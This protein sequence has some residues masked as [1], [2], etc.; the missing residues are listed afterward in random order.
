MEDLSG[1]IDYIIDGGPCDVGVES[2]VVDGLSHPPAILRPGGISIEQIRQCPGWEG[3]VV[4]YEDAALKAG[5]PRAPGMKYRHY[6]PK[7]KVFL[8]DAGFSRPS[9]KSLVEQGF[10][11]SG[12]ICTREWKVD[13]SPTALD[14]INGITNGS[15]TMERGELLGS[16]VPFER[17][18]PKHKVTTGTSAD[19][20][21]WEVYLGNTATDVARD[22]FWALRELDRKGCDVICVES[23]DEEEGDVAAAVMNRLRKAAEVQVTS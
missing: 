11:A 3:V 16:I 5:V 12:F 17:P 9:L 2:T 4:S 18:V 13:T 10:G 7:A 6:S 19:I 21:C 20:S 8:Y 15:G 23:I 22:L 1:R 14:G